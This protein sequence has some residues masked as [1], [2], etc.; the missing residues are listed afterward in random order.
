MRPESQKLDVLAG[1]VGVGQQSFDQG[2]IASAD[3][4]VLPLHLLSKQNALLGFEIPREAREQG[5]DHIHH[6]PFI[7]V[8]GFS[9]SEVDGIGDLV[10][11]GV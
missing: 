3:S 1:V 5:E 7:V 2:V 6:K 4:V 11:Y 8:D 9:D 10:F